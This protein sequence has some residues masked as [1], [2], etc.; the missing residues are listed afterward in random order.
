VSQD[1]VVRHNALP[2]SLTVTQLQQSGASGLAL[3]ITFLVAIPLLALNL[4]PAVTSVGTALAQIQSDTGMSASLASAVVAAPVWCFAAGGGIAWALRV[5]WGTAKTVAI[6]LTILTLSLAV[7]VIGGPYVLLSGTIVACLAIAVLGTMLPA[8]VHAA[9]P[10]V[11]A[12]LT[13]SYIAALGSGSAVGALITPQITDHTSWQLGASS[14]AL[15]AGAGLVIWRVAARRLP[16]KPVP[17]STRKPTPMTL[18]PIGTAWTLTLHFGLTSG[19]TFTIMGWLPSILLD[20]SHVPPHTVGWMFTVAMAL[21]V[22]FALLV[23][24]WARARRNQARLAVLLALP[25]L[26]AI[27]GL[28]FSPSGGLLPELSI[29]TVTPWVWA[30]GLGLGMPAVGLGLT[31]ISLRAD[32]ATDTAAALSSMVQGFGYA[33]AG[34]I[35]LG[36]G[37]LHSATQSWE[38]PLAALLIILCG[39]VITGIVAGLPITVHAAP[40]GQPLIIP[41][42]RRPAER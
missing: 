31:M 19:V 22:P 3:S 17:V 29:D 34:A 37:L 41:N 39:Q 12:T 21:G 35:A 26:V 25:T 16:E 1:N 14:W 6:A 20:R 15:L 13:G 23:P 2:Q 8:I 18:R 4:R 27:A 40:R 9:P 33:I 24:R 42:P 28:L 36:T 30:I 38:W 7:R 5:R 11:W 10:R 32:S